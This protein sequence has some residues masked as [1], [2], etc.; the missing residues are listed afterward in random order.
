MSLHYLMLLYM[1]FRVGH[2]IGSDTIS[3]GQS[4][5]E[6]Q[7]II[8]KGGTFELGFFSPGNSSNRYIGIWYRNN[9]VRTVVW[10]L[11]RKNPILDSFDNSSLALSYGRL[12]L[13]NG[14]NRGIIWSSLSS[15]A[16]EAILLDTG[17][18]VLRGG[19]GVLWQSFDYPTDTWLPGGRI[20]LDKTTNRS[21][22]LT[23]WRNSEDPSPGIYSFGID[24]SGSPELFIWRNLTRRDW[25][26]GVW[27][28]RNFTFAPYMSV[29]GRI[30][31]FSHVSDEDTNYFTYNASIDSP[32][33]RVVVTTTGMMLSLMWSDRIHDWA[34]FSTE[35]QDFCG[36]YEACGPYGV[37]DIDTSPMCGCLH[38][39][40]PRFPK[41]WELG[42]FSGGCVRRNALQ[43]SEE[44]ETFLR[45]TN[46]L[47]AYSQS[48][49]VGRAEICE[50]AC[51]IN[52]SCSAYSYGNSGGC[53]FWTGDLLDLQKRTY[54]GDFYLKLDASEVP[55]NEAQGKM[56]DLLL[57]NLDNSSKPITQS[58][59]KSGEEKKVLELPMF[60]FSSISTATN[61]FSAANKLGEGGFGPV[62]K[63]MRGLL[64]KYAAMK[65]KP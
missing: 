54:G 48:L 37:C 23:S 40:T 19:L 61:K 59:N 16:T 3:L 34:V 42:D 33:T 62:Y 44:K 8:S 38:G 12:N 1:F 21:L 18:F 11:N 9:P 10:V 60:S 47:P 39:F 46:I 52:C 41:D 56:Q 50:F 53:L 32:M 26:S 31:N 45:M 20:G 35:P 27:N 22:V 63:V 13:Y 2:S 58:F 64:Y 28:G 51:L 5:S 25:R 29:D 4:L 43:C 15:N 49:A 14:S 36:V 55:N 57:L 17:N 24:P 7:T 65:D 30:Y 6:G